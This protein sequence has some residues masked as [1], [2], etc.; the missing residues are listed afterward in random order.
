M[1]AAAKDALVIDGAAQRDSG[2]EFRLVYQA[3]T[4]AASGAMT[5][6]EA[7]LRWHSASLG[8]VAPDRFIPVAEDS[9]MIVEIGT[10]VLNEAAA[11]SVCGR[12]ARWANSRSASMSRHGSWPIPHLWGWCSRR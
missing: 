3:I 11:S 2:Q 12:L 7:L 5:K 4:S 1:N 9:G 10:W 8:N 6:V